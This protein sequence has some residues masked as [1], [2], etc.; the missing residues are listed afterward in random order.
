MPAPFDPIPE[1]E[2][3]QSF[4]FSDDQMAEITDQEKRG[5]YSPARFEQ[6]RP[7]QFELCIKMLTD[8][9]PKIEI[10]QALNI[11][12]KT[13]CRVADRHADRIT[14]L[15]AH[16]SK[17]CRRVAWDQVDRLER[18]PGIIPAQGIAQAV[19]YLF[20]TAQLADGRPTEI[21]EERHEVNIYEHW[22]RFVRGETTGLTGEKLPAIEGELVPASAALPPG[23][24]GLQSE[25]STPFTQGEPGPCSNFSDDLTAE[26]G[27]KQDPDTRGG[28]SPRE[29][30]A[31]CGKDNATQKF[32]ANGDSES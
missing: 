25:G 5:T 30:G 22:S 4:L 16:F 8:K 32:Y 23:A 1:P 7:R 24:S 15:E 11:T 9:W 20:E 2:P 29:G 26:N 14:E 31:D 10:A 18:N 17:K 6:L 3:P 13:V 27:A 19:K 12:E 28:E 21:T